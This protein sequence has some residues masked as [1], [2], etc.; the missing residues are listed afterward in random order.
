MVA[1]WDIVTEHATWPT[2]SVSEHRVLKL[3]ASRVHGVHTYSM[4]L[5]RTTCVVYDP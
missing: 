4:A 1:V 3:H 5:D 2:L